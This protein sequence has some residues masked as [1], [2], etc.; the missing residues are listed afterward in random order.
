MTE[1]LLTAKEVAQMLQLSR[2]A[3]YKSM[4]TGDIPYV[5]LTQKLVR[6]RISD[7]QAWLDKKLHNKQKEVS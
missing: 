6:F 1:K 7:I 2:S 3:I 5:R 4:R